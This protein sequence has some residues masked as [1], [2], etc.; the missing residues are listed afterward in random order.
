MIPTIITTL[1]MPQITIHI[2][3]ILNLIFLISS[4]W[5]A[6]KIHIFQ[7]MV[8]IFCVEIQR[9]PLKGVPLKFHTKYLTFTLKDSIFIQC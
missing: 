2:I 8:N 5:Y 7:C 3:I 9:V 4:I 6:D 1:V